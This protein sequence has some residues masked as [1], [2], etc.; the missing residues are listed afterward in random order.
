MFEVG[1]YMANCYLVGCDKTRQGVVIDPG[2][3]G[4]MIL[5]RIEENK[6]TIDKILLTH[7]HL[8][9]IGA[10]GY[11]RKALGAKVYI[12]K[13]DAEML[14][15]PE[16]NMSAY[17]PTPVQTNGADILVEDNQEIEFGETKLTVLHT[18]GHSP[19]GISLYGEG[20]VFTGDT[21]FLGSVGRTDFPNSDFDQLMSSITEKIYALPDETVIYP[22][23]GPDT[24]VGQEKQFNPF[25]RW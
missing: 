16:V 20:V 11:V 10:V 2:D 9:H 3:S 15:S 7:G 6:L 14:I 5:S 13:G 1:S 12:H 24:A 4:D 19:G 22:G 23:H 25:V 21:I 18:P 8:D 17:T